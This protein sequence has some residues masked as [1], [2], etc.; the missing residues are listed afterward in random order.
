[1]AYLSDIDL[2]TLHKKRL[3][4]KNH[5]KLSLFNRRF[6]DEDDHPSKPSSQPSIYN[7]LN[8]HQRRDKLK[9]RNPKINARV[10]SS[11][12]V[13]SD[14]SSSCSSSRSSSVSKSIDLA[15]R[16]DQD[17]Y[18]EGYLSSTQSRTR[19]GTWP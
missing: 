7:N 14:I 5:Y 2:A 3:D 8:L 10:P 1:M 9:G 12:S 16:L 17:F 15:S 6:F 13:Q 19:S 4:E 11:D 18:D